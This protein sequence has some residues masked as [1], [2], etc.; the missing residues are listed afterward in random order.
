MATDMFLKFSDNIKGEAGGDHP[1]EI[2]IVS[3]SWGMTQSGDM[4]VNTG[5]GAGKVDVQNLTFTHFIDSATPN[6]IQKCCDGTH[7]ATA[8]ITVR[9]AGGKEPVDYLKI[10]LMN[11]IISGV[12]TGGVESG[13]RITENVTLN[14]RQFKVEY[15]PQ[16]SKTGVKGTTIPVSWNIPNNSSKLD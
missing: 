3:W 6:L 12:S 7:I 2:K 13:E 14:F 10:H 15:T 11:C 4:H 5:G 1:N 8:D 9:K 16:D